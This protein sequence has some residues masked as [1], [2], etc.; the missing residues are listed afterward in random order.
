MYIYICTD[1]CDTLCTLHLH[2]NTYVCVYMY[3]Y[4]YM[5]IYI[6]VY[7]YIY[8]CICI[9]IY[10]H[11]YVYVNIYTHT[12]ICMHR[13]VFTRLY[14]IHESRKYISFPTYSR[15]GAIEDTFT[16]IKISHT[17]TSEQSRLHQWSPSKSTQG[18][19]HGDKSSPESHAVAKVHRMP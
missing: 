19:T 17:P 6:Y 10:T 16:E 5:Y 13:H 15:I 14:C 4:I 8:I 7:V 11:T 2:V 3:T 18:Y 12:Y 9:Y 1:T